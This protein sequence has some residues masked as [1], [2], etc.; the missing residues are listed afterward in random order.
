M[1]PNKLAGG[2][3]KVLLKCFLCVYQ[4]SAAVDCFSV[5]REIL[6]LILSAATQKKLDKGGRDRLTSNYQQ[7]NASSRNPQNQPN[8][9]GDTHQSNGQDQKKREN[10]KQDP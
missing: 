2:M 8:K 4:Q 10:P 1:Y 5:T 6:E 7:L 9:Q 3:D